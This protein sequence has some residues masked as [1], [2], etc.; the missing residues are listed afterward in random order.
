M[1]IKNIISLHFLMHPSTTVGH[2]YIYLDISAKTI[3]KVFV[4]LLLQLNNNYLISFTTHYRPLCTCVLTSWEFPN[5]PD[6]IYSI[7]Y[8]ILYYPNRIFGCMTSWQDGGFLGNTPICLFI[9]VFFYLFINT[10]WRW[11]YN[12]LN[13]R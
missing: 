4:I 2:I 5:V 12:A 13:K 3:V 10:Q 9:N 6:F 11:I 1:D 8:Y 7:L